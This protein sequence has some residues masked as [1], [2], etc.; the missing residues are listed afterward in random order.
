MQVVDIK[1]KTLTLL[2]HRFLG[3]GLRVYSVRLGGISRMN[4]ANEFPGDSDVADLWNT[5]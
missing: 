5:L 2:K 3:L 1:L 4:I